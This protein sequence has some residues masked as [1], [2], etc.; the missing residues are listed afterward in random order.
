MNAI[1]QNIHRI[2]CA[3]PESCGRLPE[4]DLKAE[5]IR[6][7]EGGSGWRMW[8]GWCTA[9][10]TWARLDASRLGCAAEAAG[11]RFGQELSRTPSS[12]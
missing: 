6:Q 3:I 4:H 1:A 12:D 11:Q 8:E 9:A 2:A 5:D 10:I 7:G